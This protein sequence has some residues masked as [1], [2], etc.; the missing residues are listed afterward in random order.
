MKNL[1]IAGVLVSLLGSGCL[2]TREPGRFEIVEISI[3]DG[4]FAIRPLETITITVSQD[5]S[6]GSLDGI[7]LQRGIFPVDV[8]VAYNPANHEIVID[9][10]LPLERET[11]YVLSIDGLQS[12]EGVFAEPMSVGFTTV[13]NPL[14]WNGS[15]NAN[16]DL[17]S[18]QELVNDERGRNVENR[19]FGAGSDGVLGTQDDVVTYLF[20]ATYG[21]YDSM[22]VSY[23]GPGPDGVFETSDDEIGF[24]STNEVDPETGVTLSVSYDGPGPDG[25][26]FTTDDD[27]SGHNFTESSP[28]FFRHEEYTDPGPDGDWFTDDDVITFFVQVLTDLTSQLRQLSSAPGADGEFGTPDDDGTVVLFDLNEWGDV[29]HFTAYNDKGP[30][31]VFFTA[32]DV[33]SQ[34]RFHT[35]GDSGELLRIDETSTFGDSHVV[36]EYDTNLSNT[37]YVDI[38]DPGPDGEYGTTDDVPNFYQTLVY[39]ELG[40]L[41]EQDSYGDPGVDGDWFTEDDPLAGRQEYDA[42][43]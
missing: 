34:E 27:V 26:W 29:T 8:E 25:E 11:D 42:D 35:F 14:S 2:V 22:Y 1:V 21:E 3:E 19:I 15:F 10:V 20:V 17:V 4:A 41:I 7:A 13:V 32:D 23:V 38:A 24:T 36:L 39:D 5:V 28:T 9:P 37:S 6:L 33:L 16:G 31:G 18:Y 30:D 12:H 40:S 43:R